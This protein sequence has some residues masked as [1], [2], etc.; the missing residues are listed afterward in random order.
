VGERERRGA[1][2]RGRAA[3]TARQEGGRWSSKRE[4]EF[5]A[6]RWL[7][8]A[9]ARWRRAAIILVLRFFLQRAPA[10]VTRYGDSDKEEDDT[11]GTDLS[12]STGSNH[13]TNNYRA[14]LSLARENNNLPVHFFLTM[15]IFIVVNI[16]HGRIS[17]NYKIKFKI[18]ANSLSLKT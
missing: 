3:A 6:I 14:H 12:V 18:N 9:P 7:W 2:R 15:N 1:R 4:E 11:G 10:R 8:V 5:A 17:G 13:L 16:V